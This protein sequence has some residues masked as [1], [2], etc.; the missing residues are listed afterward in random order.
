MSHAKNFRR[1]G[2]ECD[3]T[4]ITEYRWQC[5]YCGNVSPAMRDEREEPTGWQV[6]FQGKVYGTAEWDQLPAHF[7]TQVHRDEWTDERQREGVYS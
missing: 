1:N 6:Y 3:M 7:C 5:E 2:R 4:I